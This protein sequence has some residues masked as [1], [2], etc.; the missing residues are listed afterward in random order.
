MSYSWTAA[1]IQTTQSDST[2]IRSAE[3]I[4]HFLSSTSCIFTLNILSSSSSVSQAFVLA[5][6]KLHCYVHAIKQHGR[7][8]G[9]C[10]D[11]RSIL[12]ALQSAINYMHTLIIARTSAASRRFGSP[13]RFASNLEFKESI[14]LPIVGK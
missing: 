8:R 4:S 14:P 1:S 7:G 6:M 13:C 5:S 2:S 12:V 3:T 11:H 9:P 10:L